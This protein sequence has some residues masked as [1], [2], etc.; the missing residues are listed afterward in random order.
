M[1]EMNVRELIKLNKV[2]RTMK[3]AK[4]RCKS[5]K[6]LVDTIT[7]EPISIFNNNPEVIFRLSE[8]K[9]SKESQDRILEL[10]DKII[11]ESEQ[12][13]SKDKPKTDSYLK[14]LFNFLPEDI[15]FNYLIEAF[16]HKRKNRRLI[17]VTHLKQRS[18]SNNEVNLL[19]E[20]YDECGEQVLLEV[21]AR[22]YDVDNFTERQTAYILAKLENKYWKCRIIERLLIEREIDK[23]VK[24]TLRFFPYE[25]FY[26]MGRLKDKRILRYIEKYIDDYLDD[27]DSLGIIIWA[28]GKVGAKSKIVKIERFIEENFKDEIKFIESTFKERG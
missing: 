19:L 4:L 13:S 23:F 15:R 12:I 21:L 26:A 9:I 11:I 22:N 28:L 20:K 6:E 8:M 3:L 17:G 25:S 1:K 18:Y 7:S 27:I 5:E 14:K 24:M 16:N 2:R 10:I